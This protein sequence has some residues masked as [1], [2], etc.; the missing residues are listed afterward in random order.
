MRDYE[1]K[2]PPEWYTKIERFLTEHFW[3]IL[4]VTIYIIFLVLAFTHSYIPD[5]PEYDDT[6]R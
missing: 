2:C 3:L 1:R 6:A 4:I 5:F